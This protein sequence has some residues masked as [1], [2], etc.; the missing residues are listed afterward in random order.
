VEPELRRSAETVPQPPNVSQ[1]WP[2]QQQTLVGTAMESRRRLNAAP[3]GTPRYDMALPM[4]T[5]A[6]TFCG[7]SVAS[8]PL[9]DKIRSSQLAFEP[10]F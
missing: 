7:V 8:A 5:A 1:P 4:A 2:L 9:L 10:P 6:C 3:A